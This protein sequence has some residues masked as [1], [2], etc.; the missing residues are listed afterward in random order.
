MLRFVIE[1]SKMLNGLIKSIGRNSTSFFFLSFFLFFFLSYLLTT[2]FYPLP[3]VAA[4]RDIILDAKN[5]NLSRAKATLFLTPRTAT[6]LEGSTFE[7]PIFINTHGASINTLELKVKFDQNKFIIVRPSGNKSIIALWLEPPAYSNTEGTVRLVGLI[8]NGIT[9]QSGLITAMTFRAIA[10]GE[11]TVDIS[12]QSR[13]LANDGLG[14]EVITEFDRGRY[15]VI[16]KP[17]DGV[18]VFSETHPFQ[19]SWYNNNNPIII[20]EKPLGISDFSFLF[21]DK[22]FTIPDNSPESNDTTIGYQSMADGLWYFHIKAHKKDTWGPAT[23][24][25]VRIDTTPPAAF[26]PKVEALSAT[27]VSRFFISFFTTDALSGVDYYEIGAIQ[28]ASAA[29]SS[30]LFIQSESPYQLVPQSSGDTRVV[31]RAFDKA[32][33]V[34]QGSVDISIPLSLLTFLKNN[35]IL[36]LLVLL[37]TAHYFF[38]HRFLFHMRRIINA[39]KKEEKK[40]KNEGEKRSNK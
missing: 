14:T 28:R 36:I 1:I 3:V 13:V 10:P 38:G 18:K 37:L 33:N 6:I 23:H 17:P 9:T 12:S 20:W 27:I 7:V 24:F 4:V 21:D 34:Q 22:P 31:V 30:P 5:L 26:Q 25:L 16:P 15:T 19:E 29:S 32:G 39:I 40:I 8:P 2:L 11:G 35:A